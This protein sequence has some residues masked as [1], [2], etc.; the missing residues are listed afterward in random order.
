LK[1]IDRVVFGFVTIMFWGISIYIHFKPPIEFMQKFDLTLFLLPLPAYW[2]IKGRTL[3]KANESV[4]EVLVG[5]S[6]FIAAALLTAVTLY[7]RFKLL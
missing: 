5:I 4:K 3:I 7:I 1:P 6:M 2:I